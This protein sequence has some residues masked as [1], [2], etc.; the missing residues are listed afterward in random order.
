MSNIFTLANKISYDNR[1]K[2][3]QYKILH[4]YIPT[5]K[6]LCKMKKID[7]VKCTFCSLYCEDIYHLFY[8]YLVVKEIWFFIEKICNDRLNV[9]HKFTCCDILLGFMTET[10]SA[11]NITINRLILYGKYYILQCK[12]NLLKP[13]TEGFLLALRNHSTFDDEIMNLL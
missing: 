13:S 5:N 6:L 12:Y 10:L 9:T 2:E 4:Q 8:A 3:M 11:V 1:I 7:S